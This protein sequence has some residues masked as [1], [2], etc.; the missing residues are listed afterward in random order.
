MW[1]LSANIRSD[2]YVIAALC[3]VVV[4]SWTG[5]KLGRADGD[6]EVKR[7]YQAAQTAVMKRRAEIETLRDQS[8]ED[9][10]RIAKL[11][12]NARVRC[13]PSAPADRLPGNPDS[14]PARDDRAVGVDL[15]PVL[16]Q[17][18][19]TFGQVNKATTKGKPP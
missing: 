10:I 1:P 14:S 17:C 12:R 5:F 19:R 2:W 18:L 6:R 3:A 8:D 15:T 11:S 7:M 9:A 4:S 16:R 13:Y